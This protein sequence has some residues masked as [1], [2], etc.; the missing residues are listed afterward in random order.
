MAPVATT[1]RI[2]GMTEHLL[3]FTPRAGRQRAEKD[4]VVT[5][6]Y[7]LFDG[8]DGEL[9]EYRDNLMYL[10][11]GYEARLPGL[12]VAVEGHGAG[13][14]AEVELSSDDAFGPYDPNLVITD[15][16]ENF[17]A[18]AGQVG[19]ELEGHTPDGTVVLFRVTH[20]EDGRITVNGNHPLAGRNLRFIVEIKNIRDA[21][22]QEL[23]AGSA[24]RART[25]T[26]EA[27]RERH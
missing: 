16:A 17:P 22:A 15:T 3:H 12:Q 4:K 14:R 11:G 21:T 1:A 8:D 9:L 6:K 7:A 5:L 19:T 13:Y 23:A 26:S 10:H 18:E 25:P 20:V 2:G 24:L 27:P